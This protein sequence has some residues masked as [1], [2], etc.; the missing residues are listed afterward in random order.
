MKKVLITLAVICYLLALACLALIIV[1]AC[2]NVKATTIISLS[3]SMIASLVNG[4]MFTLY[5]KE[6]L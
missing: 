1:S 5:A 2:F 6:K 3:L 4:T